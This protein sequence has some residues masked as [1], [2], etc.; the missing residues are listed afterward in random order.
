M[1]HFTELKVKLDLLKKNENID[2]T[3][4]YITCLLLLIYCTHKI[5]H[6]MGSSEAVPK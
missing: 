6:I 3:G 1:I 2:N 4:Y 5:A